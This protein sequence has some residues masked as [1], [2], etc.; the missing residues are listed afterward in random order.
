MKKNKKLMFVL[1]LFL[2]KLF[3]AIFWKPFLLFK[4]GFEMPLKYYLKIWIP[5]VVIAALVLISG[6]Y[7]IDLC[8][9][10]KP[11]NWLEFCI[12]GAIVTLTGCFLNAALVLTLLPGGK[13]LR[14]RLLMF[15]HNRVRML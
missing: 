1:S 3:S 5:V 10:R 6:N 7:L 2:S 9:Y 14:N 12:Y 15:I 13:M 11:V 8:Q 4:Y